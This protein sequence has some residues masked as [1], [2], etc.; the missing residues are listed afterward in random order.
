MQSSPWILKYDRLLDRKIDST[1]ILE[2]T[3]L[4]KDDFTSIRDG[5]KYELEKIN[6][7]ANY[8]KIK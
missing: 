2:V 6:K 1:K 7:G 4:S 3:G 8:I 5:I